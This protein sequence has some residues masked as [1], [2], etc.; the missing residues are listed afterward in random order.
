[1]KIALKDYKGSMKVVEFSMDNLRMA[2]IQVISGDEVLCMYYDD[3][4]ELEFDSSN[5]RIRDYHDDDRIVY[6]PD[7][8]INEFAEYEARL[9]DLSSAPSESEVK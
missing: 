2:I 3:G 9:R 5:S 1:M 7:M 6:S 8:G 4:K